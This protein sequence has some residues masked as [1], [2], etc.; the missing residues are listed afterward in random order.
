[1]TVAYVDSSALTKL[2]LDEPDSLAMRRWYVESDHVLCSRIGILETRRAVARGQPDPDH[3]DVI[4]RSVEIVEFDADIAWQAAV[5]G[6]LSLR[7]LDAI[8]LASAVAL[9]PE[10]DSFVTYDDRLAIAAHAVGLPAVR[11]A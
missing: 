4:L 3:L 1:M 10:V 9:L 2:V 6:P 5:V 11:P 7:T 8:H